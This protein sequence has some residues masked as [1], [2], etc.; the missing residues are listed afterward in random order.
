MLLLLICARF[1]SSF[2]LFHELGLVIAPLQLCLLARERILLHCLGYGLAQLA[3]HGLTHPVHSLLQ[4]THL[5]LDTL[6]LL[7]GARP[8]GLNER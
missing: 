4:K 8:N 5:T 2:G 1:P 3:L 7:H 6:F